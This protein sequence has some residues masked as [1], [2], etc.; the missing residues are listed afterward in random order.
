MTKHPER[1][2]SEVQADINKL[3]D[4]LAVAHGIERHN[5]LLVLIHDELDD[6]DTINKLRKFIGDTIIPAAY[7]YPKVG[8]E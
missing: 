7:P 5:N 1:S 8:D 6:C 4:E 2:S 3:T